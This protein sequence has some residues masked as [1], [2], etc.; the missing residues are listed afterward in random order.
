MHWF[1]KISSRAH[2]IFA[3][4]SDRVRAKLFF[5]LRGLNFKRIGTE[6]KVLGGEFITLGKSVGV[7]RF[8][9]FEGVGSYA[10]VKFKPSIYIGNS[11]NM[12][13]F[14]HL[15]AVGR[16]HISD[17]VLIGS[18]VYIGDH[19]HGRV[20]FLS[21]EYGVPPALRPLGEAGDIYIGENVWICDGVVILAGTSVAAGSIIA[22]NSVVKIVCDKPA[23]IGGVPAKV[24]RYVD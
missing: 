3:K 12:S 6:L 24:I 11:V 9:W 8:C 13:D 1:Y 20:R 21:E 10:G 19:S 22:A 15:S 18:H 23:I 7:G 4:V 17:G 2:D 16:I 5:I 14:V